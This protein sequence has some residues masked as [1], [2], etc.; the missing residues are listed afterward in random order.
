ML[1]E[2]F[3]TGA[4]A[5]LVLD[6]GAYLLGGRTA[7]D[8]EPPMLD[9]RTAPLAEAFFRPGPTY[10]IELDDGR[11]L[12]GEVSERILRGGLGPDSSPR[13]SPTPITPADRNQLVILDP[14]QQRAVD[15]PS[16]TSLVVDGEAGV[17]KTLVALYR[18]AELA[19]R[20]PQFR[21]LV[22][23]PTEGLRRLVRLIA[24][25]LGVDKLE[26]AVFDD[27]ILERARTVFPSLPKRASEGASAQVIA[28]KRNPAVRAVL[29]DFIDWKPPRGVD[30][31]KISRTR[32]RLLHLWGDASR[33]QRIADASRVLPARA[34][35]Q[36]MQHTRKQ[37]E[38]TTE[39]QM[40]HVDADR[41]VALDGKKLD[42]GTPTQDANTFD[43]EDLP[44]LFE[45]VRRGALPGAKLP[46]YDHIVIDEA[47]LRAPM[48]LAAIADALAP[49]GTVTVA[50]D[51]RQATDESAWF[52]DWSAARTEL[53]RASWSDVTLAVTYR[54]VP[55]IADFA[56]DMRIPAEQGAVWTTQTDGALA[57]AAQLCW[58]LDAL[59]TRDPWR[60]ICVIA[61]NPE[62]ARRLHADLSRGLDPILVLDGDFR[63]EPG[64]LVTTAT[65]ISGLEFDAVI[66]PDLTPG[67][68]PPSP[69][70][71]RAL[72]VAATRARDW[73]W[74]LT[75]DEWS[76]L[77]LGTRP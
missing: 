71:A 33:L 27:W 53:R 67:F 69:E 32:Q 20:S 64:L 41:L 49:R 73:L 36:T 29:D 31:D 59:I 23:V 46:V 12:E 56:R 43:A 22:L 9:W 37:F 17:G 76:P 77:V 1:D 45:L 74:L 14:E 26:I 38:T 57:Q 70:L 13:P 5:Y 28:L 72:Y 75:P 25:R 60:Q 65:A 50:G 2:H 58:H 4:G 11:I 8:R 34:I 3:A 66:I 48:E 51:H 61:R 6:K 15:L 18:V 47:Q 39:K 52:I 19:R 24:D 40:A 62:H 30:D 54:S 35:A 21:A 63:F 42:A 7:L 44:V 55:A 10:S 16:D 68:Y